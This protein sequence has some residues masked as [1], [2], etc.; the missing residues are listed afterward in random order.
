MQ[1]VEHLEGTMTDTEAGHSSEVIF[2]YAS[3]EPGVGQ[4]LGSP[5]TPFSLTSVFEWLQVAKVI[6]ASIIFDYRLNG[7]M[8]RLK[9]WGLTLLK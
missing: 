8:Q 6:E 5:F 3:R 4:T 9:H 2:L 7:L 1:T